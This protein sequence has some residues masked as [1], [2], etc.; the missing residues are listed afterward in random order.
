[1]TPLFNRRRFFLAAAAVVM[2]AAALVF[3][4]LGAADVCG[5]NEAVEGVVVQQ[6]V[7][8]GA[9]VFPMLNRPSMSPGSK[10][11]T[12]SVSPP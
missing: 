8:H 6:M 5:A 3:H 11:N 2:L 12:L 1:M 4:G 10:R 9:L 7:E